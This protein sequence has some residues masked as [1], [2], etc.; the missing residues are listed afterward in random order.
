MKQK[1]GLDLQDCPDMVSDL[2]YIQA[3][4]KNEITSCN[5]EDQIK[6]KQRKLVWGRKDFKVEEKGMFKPMFRYMRVGEIMY[7]SMLRLLGR[8]LGLGDSSATWQH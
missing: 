8:I 6:V 1:C 7:N 4:K 5:T 2:P 3:R